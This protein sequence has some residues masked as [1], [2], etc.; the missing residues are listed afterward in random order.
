MRKLLVLLMILCI[1]VPLFAGCRN[2][3]SLTDEP[4][5]PDEPPIS[6]NPLDPNEGEQPGESDEPEQ[7]DIPENRLIVIEDGLSDFRIVYS[8]YASDA[9]KQEALFLQTSIE[10]V[11]GVRLPVVSD[12]KDQN[13]NAGIKEILL[14]K[15]N[16]PESAA[17]TKE[18][19]QGGYG[20]AVLNSKI[21]LACT[22]DSIN[23]AVAFLLNGYFGY[24]E[25]VL[26]QS[27]NVISMPMDTK[28]LVSPK[29]ASEVVLYIAND[30]LSYIDELT[31]ALCREFDTVRIATAATRLTSVFSGT[32]SRLVIVA[33][34]ESLPCNATPFIENFL[35]QNGRILLLGGPAFSNELY[36][37]DGKL[38][39]MNTYR[40]YVI[41]DF[42]R[43]DVQIV[44]NMSDHSILHAL[45]PADNNDS[46]PT[47][48]V[49]DYGLESSAG[50]LYHDVKNVSQ[51]SILAT[52]VKVD[53]D[54]ANVVSFYARPGDD[55]T[56]SFSFEVEESDG[57]RWFVAVPFSNDEWTPYVYHANEFTWF[58]G[59][60]AK[61]DGAPDFS[62]VVRIRIGFAKSHH[63]VT[64]GHHSYYISD[65]AFCYSDTDFTFDTLSLDGVSPLY[66]QYPI[67][68]AASISAD[69]SQA[70]LSDRDYVIPSELISRHPGI[71][72]IGYG[73]DTCIRFIPLLTVKNDQGLVSGHAAW[74]DIYATQTGANGNRE[75][76][77]VGYF[78]ACSEDFYNENGI[79]AVTE[80]ARAMT[81]NTFIVDGGTTEYTYLAD[82]T[83]RILAGI[84]YVSLGGTE[85][86]DVV[87]TVMLY[88]G[89][90]LLA[91]YSSS[92]CDAISLPNSIQAIQGEFDLS[93]GTPNRVVA[94]LEKDGRVIDRVEHPIY[95]W[96][97]KPENERSYVYIEDGYFKRDGEVLNLFGVNFSPASQAARPEKDAYWNL[98]STYESY[99]T[100]GGYDPTVILNDLKRIKGLG[101]NAV[102]VW[103]N[104]E[105]IESCNNVLDLLRMCEELGLYVDVSLRSVAYPL[106]NYDADAVELMIERLHLNENDIIVAYDIAWEPRIG[107]YD[108]SWSPGHKYGSNY[109]IGRQWLDD[110]FT[111]WT[112]T[113][114]GSIQ[115]AETA[116]G[117]AV[118]RTENGSLLV[119]DDMLDDT[120]G[121]YRKAVAAYYRFLDDIINTMMQENITHI[122]SLVPN[123][124]V[125]FRMSMSGSSYRTSTFLPSTHCFDF[126]SLA[127][128]VDFMQPEGYQLAAD[129]NHALQIMFA[130]AYARYVKPDAPIVWKEYGRSVWTKSDDGNFN[131]SEEYLKAAEDYYR[132]A[133]EYCYNSNTAGMFCWYSTGGYRTDE[134]SDYGIWNPDGSDRP[135]TVLLREYAPKFIN[136][137]QYNN[138]V[139]I[140]IE[141]DDYT[142]GL[143]GVYDAVKS[144]LARAYAAGTS[145]TF[146]DASQGQN[147]T[148][149]YADTLLDEY[150]ADAASGTATAPL[151]YVNGIF[152]S[153]SV[154]EKNGKQYADITICNTK[155]SIWRAGTVSIVSTGS[156]LRYTISSEV[157]YLED[158]VVTVELNDRTNQELRLCLNGIMFG[159]AYQIAFE[160]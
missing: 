32:R 96:S 68:N 48:S 107:N 90:K 158:V 13:N 155:Q 140:T 136:R 105:H 82:S 156:S 1:A 97:P 125:S 6:E 47:V 66:E 116:W 30:K 49:G 81:G 104:V 115:N 137:A 59:N 74:L 95:Y 50:Q 67:T 20:I 98:S 19:P 127:A 151:R 56:P 93:G 80:L 102:A 54:K 36:A 92:E 138:T 76:A 132:Y 113:Q 57:T 14:G 79:L 150:V 100:D 154:Y 3:S 141:R 91:K 70:F 160:E 152:K 122:R 43:S 34:A 142:G 110:D 37:Y 12:W 119:T 129:E 87:A 103:F 39:P 124:L 8:D 60:E 85:D 40:Q 42:D 38:V 25:G 4:S 69:A 157:G 35:D 133:L 52:K 111:V 131:P 88:Q 45:T 146:V 5:A 94:T 15:T 99:V 106:Q 22:A 18:T 26:P 63:S 55:H 21:V 29:D 23:A 24:V 149:A 78:G 86:K 147:G 16:R 126:Q 144:D 71:S 77:M 73:K 118:G 2:H 11:T 139:Y 46:E 51:W 112:I 44:L 84:K 145:I 17:L 64:A 130:N 10:Q 9:I 27:R 7:S 114:Y 31:Q 108:G 101:M 33:G 121:K 117:I 28:I 143:F 148:Y 65:V 53:F 128:S 153:V 72:G 58:S 109:F 135:V 83:D 89:D 120:S 134:K 159:P 75:G 123:Q 62:D 61:K 41:G